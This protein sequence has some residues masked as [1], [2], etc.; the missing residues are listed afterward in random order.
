MTYFRER[1]GHGKCAPGEV[2]STLKRITDKAQDILLSRYSTIILNIPTT[3][4]HFVE[5]KKFDSFSPPVI[6]WS[7]E[8]F[9][10]LTMSKDVDITRFQEILV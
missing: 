2:C 6:C 5:L 8:D 9:L 4:L 3:S 10:A 1:L 7:S